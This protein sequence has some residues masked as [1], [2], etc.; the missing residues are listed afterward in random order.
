MLWSAAEF[1]QNKSA[2][3]LGPMIESFN[4]TKDLIFPVNLWQDLLCVFR[5]HHTC[6]GSYCEVQLCI[7][8]G[9]MYRKFI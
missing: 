4:Y 7:C 1:P 9:V 3:H 6:S 8:S 5:H 2:S